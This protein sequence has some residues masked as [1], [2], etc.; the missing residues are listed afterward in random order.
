MS[1]EERPH[2]SV[3]ICGHV[4]SGKSTIGAQLLNSLR[5]P[6]RR[7]LLTPPRRVEE[8]ADVQIFLDTRP[9][10]REMGRTV[11]CKMK[12]FVTEHWRYTLIDVPGHQRYITN[13]IAGAS[14]ADAALLLVPADDTFA[15]SLC[16]AGG[17]VPEGGSRQ[18]ARVLHTFGVTQLCIVVTKLDGLAPAEQPARFR[19]VVQ[20][21][22]R[23][24][25]KSGWKSD[26]LEQN[27]A[28]VPEAGHRN[29]NI[30]SRSDYFPWWTGQDVQLPEVRGSALVHIH[31]LYDVLDAIFAPPMRC[32][33]AP[34]LMTV[35]HVVPVYRCL[36]G[37]VEQGTLRHW[38]V[39]DERTVVLPRSLDGIFGYPAPKRGQ[40]L[41]LLEEEERYGELRS[42]EAQVVLLF[43]PS[44]MKLGHVALAC[45]CTGR[46]PVRLLD[47]KW[48]I[49]KE[50]G[51]RKVEGP[52]EPRPN[53]MALCTFQPLKPFLCDSFPSCSKLARILF[54]EHHQVMMLGKVVCCH[55]KEDNDKGGKKK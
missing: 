49:S 26:F 38:K 33:N 40:A 35:L 16:S 20:E 1:L 32:I 6:V 52:Q 47:I 17:G 34:L 23:S 12:E 50:T 13:M 3:A 7:G 29:F 51:G 8:A 9:E 54:V 5:P 39:K 46:A 18:H 19:E 25:R 42:F 37:R 21:T 15:W 2:L 30:T 11:I 10:E 53:D 45:V 55:R 28:F 24:L 44:D 41:M 14:L 4:G 43:S 48:K 27:V 36:V 31:C 22:K